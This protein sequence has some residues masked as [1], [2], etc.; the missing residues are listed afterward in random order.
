MHADSRDRHGD[1]SCKHARAPCTLSTSRLEHA[2]R[3]SARAS[4]P[5]TVSSSFSCCP[6]GANT[7]NTGNPPAPKSRVPKLMVPTSDS[8]CSAGSCVPP[9][10]DRVASGPAQLSRVGD[11]ADAGDSNS[12]TC[13]SG[14][15]SSSAVHG[16]ACV[17]DRCCLRGRGDNADASRREAAEPHIVAARRECHGATR[18][19]LVA[20]R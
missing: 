12:R 8:P 1:S 15:S 18:D 17:G 2:S 7:P 10:G 4:G 16:T 5:A 14:S 19:V 3:G 6:N 11:P 13:S 9:A 20:A